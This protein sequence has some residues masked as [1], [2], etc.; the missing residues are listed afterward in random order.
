MEWSFSM[1]H[2]VSGWE[3]G[4]RIKN[5]TWPEWWGSS[6]ER[7]PS[8]LWEYMD[9]VLLLSWNGLRSLLCFSSTVKSLFHWLWGGKKNK[10]KRC[11]G[12]RCVKQRYTAN[13]NRLL[14][15]GSFCHLTYML[16]S[17]SPLI[18]SVRQ[19]FIFFEVCCSLPLPQRWST[20]GI[21]EAKHRPDL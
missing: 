17:D 1:S 5:K 8:D 4:I 12:S 10:T 21:L 19:I 20:E 2:W 7:L 13:R 9:V 15:V 16:D 3:N 18:R 14:K 6:G 11:W